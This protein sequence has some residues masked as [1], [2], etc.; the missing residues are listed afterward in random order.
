[1]ALV[2]PVLG[3]LSLMDQRSWAQDTGFS[4]SN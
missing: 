3:Q 4:L 1:M 2:G